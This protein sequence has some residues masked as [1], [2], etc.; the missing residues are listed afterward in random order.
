M[1]DLVESPPDRF[2]FEIELPA[3]L[4]HKKA[5]AGHITVN[6]TDYDVS[7]VRMDRPPEGMNMVP[8]KIRMGP[9]KDHADRQW[10]W[11]ALNNGGI[12][13]SKAPP[14]QED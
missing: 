3:E 10:L 9:F 12:S 5:E 8:W 6:E 13:V 7:M 14:Q 2:V 1:S 4:T 11:E